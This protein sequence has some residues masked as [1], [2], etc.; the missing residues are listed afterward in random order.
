M[1]DREIEEEYLR[2]INQY[3]NSSTGITTFTLNDGVKSVCFIGKSNNTKGKLEVSSE[4]TSDTLRI[5]DELI[6]NL[7]GIP[8][9][10]LQDSLVFSDNLTLTLNQE[11]G[12]PVNATI[13]PQTLA[14]SDYIYLKLNGTT[15]ISLE[16]VLLLTEDILLLNNQTVTFSN[17]TSRLTHGIIE[18][19]KPV[20]WTQTVLLNETDS[21][22]NILLELPADAQNIQIQKTDQNGTS[23]AIPDEQIIIIEPELEPVE[24]EY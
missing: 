19:G 6:L 1:V 11:Q 12:T 15:Y 10:P 16:E 22:Q 5:T 14:F 9:I 17:S 23:S 13:L 18:M 2:Y 21:V 4:E 8:I 7:N 20:D 24:N 3:T